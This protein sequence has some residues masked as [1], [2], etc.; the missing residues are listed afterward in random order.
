MLLC[1]LYPKSYFLVHRLPPLVY[2][3][4]HCFQDF[5]LRKMQGMAN[6]EDYQLTTWHIISWWKWWWVPCKDTAWGPTLSH[7]T[8][9]CYPG[10]H[11]RE[12]SSWI[13]MIFHLHNSSYFG[14]HDD[15]MMGNFIFSYPYYLTRDRSCPGVFHA[16]A[17]SFWEDMHVFLK[18]THSNF[19]I[20]SACKYSRY[21]SGKWVSDYLHLEYGCKLFI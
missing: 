13:I 5:L 18:L 15:L 11:E 12:E 4:Y 20:L 21:N 14:L 16:D 19:H 10:F 7:G 2:M 3:E 8:K 17:F 6:H 1:Q 9:L